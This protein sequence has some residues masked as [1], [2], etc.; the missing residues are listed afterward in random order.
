MAIATNGFPQGN[1][2]FEIYLDYSY[3]QDHY[4]NTTTV[5]VTLGLKLAKAAGSQTYS[6]RGSCVIGGWENRT[7]HTG[8]DLRGHSVGDYVALG[9]T[10]FSYSHKADGT[11]D[12]ITINAYVDC[13]NT[14]QGVGTI[15]VTIYP[16]RI[17]RASSVDTHNFTV[18]LNSATMTY[19][20]TSASSSFAH[21]VTVYLPG[22]GYVRSNWGDSCYGTQMFSY[23]FTEW[24][25]NQILTSMPNSTTYRATTRIETRDA[26]GTSLG[27]SDSWL[28]ITIDPASN[29][30]S[31]SAFTHYDSRPETVQLTGNNQ[32]L[33]KGQSRLVASIPA[34]SKAA[35]AIGTS[36][37]KYVLSCGDASAEA[38]FSSTAAVTIALDGPASGEIKVAAVDTRGNQT[39]VSRL[40]TLVP[41]E[42][43]QIAKAAAQ[44][45]G[46]IGAKTKLSLSGTFWDANF[47]GETTDVYANTMTGQYRYRQTNSSTWSEPQ[48]FAVAGRSS[49]LSF[50]D[51]I[52]GNLVPASEGFTP[53]QS[54]ELEIS[55]ADR[56]S[57]TSI[58]A[59]LASGVPVLDLYRVGTSVG[60]A[61]GS[62]YDP[63]TGG[64]LQIAGM[65]LVSSGKT[66]KGY[67]V[68]FYDGTMIQ[69]GVQ[70]IRTFDNSGYVFNLPLS[71]VDTN[72][73]LVP[74]ISDFLGSVGRVVNVDYTDSLGSCNIWLSE[75]GSSMASES[76]K[77]SFIALGRWK[78]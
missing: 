43:P 1:Q 45:S 78:E 75:N 38:L 58:T 39:I 11:I 23:A 5:Y 42:P 24:E 74:N 61:V 19:H 55:V 2:N 56:L 52:N 63:K 57:S 30:P 60:L 62:T 69:Y 9:S 27:T 65:P 6:S 73:S 17:P 64:G 72:W 29:A 54:F 10:D 26:G 49:R 15:S 8:Y 35:P 76:L 28:N 14:G 40:A 20:I 7:V 22:G 44:R 21:Q 31:F 25:R 70:S 67:W 41:Y 33:I 16:D 34:A 53:S 68:K 46:G 47:R 36:M 37:S 51:F 50:D 13:S 12:G 18:Y 32:I 59:S 48:P 4:A 71:F 3:S 66:S 77:I